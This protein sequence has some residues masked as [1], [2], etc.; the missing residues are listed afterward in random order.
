VD[1]IKTGANTGLAKV[2]VQCSVS[3]F[4]VKSATFSKRKN[5]IGKRSGRPTTIKLTE[6]YETIGRHINLTVDFFPTRQPNISCFIFLA[7]THF[8]KTIFANAQRHPIR[9]NKLNV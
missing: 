2:A 8:F 3:T 9:I 4:V 5:V 6:Y 7:D 1:K